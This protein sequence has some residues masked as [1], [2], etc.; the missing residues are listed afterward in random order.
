M[1]RERELIQQFA[2]TI[3]PEMQSVSKRFAPSFESLIDET[4]F[5]INLNILASKYIRVLIDGRKPT[6]IGAPKGDPTLQQIIL[7]WIKDKGITP[8]ANKNGKVPT[9]ESLSWAISKSIHLY[10]TRLY[11]Q[12]GGNEIFEP[13]ITETRIN[14]LLSQL[15][16]SYYINIESDLVKSLK[17]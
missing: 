17:K 16:R 1:L 12:G 7:S 2:N 14:S 8:R 5:G 6:K 11:Q 10:G 9:I 3:V 15:E 13:I 4:E